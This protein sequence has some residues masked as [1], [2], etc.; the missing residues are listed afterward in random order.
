MIKRG[1]PIERDNL[2][3]YAKFLFRYFHLLSFENAFVMGEHF[4]ALLTMI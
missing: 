3:L 2:F 1:C 4:K